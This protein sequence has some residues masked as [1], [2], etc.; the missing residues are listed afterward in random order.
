M[1]YQ[2]IAFKILYLQKCV[3]MGIS[4]FPLISRL[5]PSQQKAWGMNMNNYHPTC[6]INLSSMFLQHWQKVLEQGNKLFLY[7]HHLPVHTSSSKL[8]QHLTDHCCFWQT[9][10]TEPKEQS[11]T[12]APPFHSYLLIWTSCLRTYKSELE[13]KAARSC[14]RLPTNNPHHV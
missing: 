13:W 8:Q 2:I 5:H 11:S 12:S 14:F 10:Q 9:G 1:H 7:V 6:L 4:L 3:E